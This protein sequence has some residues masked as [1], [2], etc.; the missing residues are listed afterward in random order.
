[1]GNVLRHYNIKHVISEDIA[2]PSQLANF[3]DQPLL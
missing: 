1:M 3:I 2:V